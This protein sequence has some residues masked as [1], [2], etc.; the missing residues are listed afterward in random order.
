MV[1]VKE[2]VVV[3]ATV[4]L[5]FPVTSIYESRSICFFYTQSVLGTSTE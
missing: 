1:S 4:H 3:V 2:H 5:I